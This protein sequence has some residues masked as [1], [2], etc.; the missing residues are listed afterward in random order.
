MARPLLLGL[1]AGLAAAV[2][3]KQQVLRVVPQTDAELRSLASVWDDGADWWR[4]PSAVGQAAYVHPAPGAPAIPAAA[5]TA[6]DKR[7]ALRVTRVKNS[8]SFLVAHTQQKNT[9]CNTRV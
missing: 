6:N 4:L 5:N 3:Q 9:L 7:R 2:P 1:C 8:F